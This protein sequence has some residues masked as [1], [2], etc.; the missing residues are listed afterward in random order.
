M[1]D[2]TSNETLRQM[3]AGFNS[4]QSAL[5]LLPA[6]SGSPT[7]GIGQA[8]VS[9]PPMPV[10]PHPSE[11]AMAALQRHNEM[12]QQTLQAAQATRYQPPPSSPTPS[13]GGLSLFN[14]FVANALGG[15]GGGYGLPSPSM[16]T[17]PAYGMFRPSPASGML[18]YGGA[19]RAPSIYNPLAPTLPSAHFATPAM[20]SLQVMQSQESQTMGTMAGA[21]EFGLGVA[22]SVVGGTLGS[23]FGPLGTIAGSWL[24]SKVGHLAGGMM[25]G[26]AVQDA[27]RAR[28]IQNTTAPFMVT[29][30]SLGAT[31]QGMSTSAALQTA[32][33]MRH[34]VHDLDFERTGFNTQDAMRIMGGAAQHGLLTG[35]QSPEEMVRRVKEI[36]KSV[37]L[38]MQITG[39]PDVRSALA[40]LGQMRDLGFQG[41]GAQAG[42]VANRA[43]FARMAGVSQAAAHEMFGL[44]GAMM[45]QQVGLAGATGYSAGMAGGAFANIAASSGALNDLQLS[46]AGGKSGLAQ[47]NAM[48]QLSSMQSDV[49][50]AASLKRGSK[51]LEVDMDAYRRAQGMTVGEVAREAAE[52]IHSMGSEGIFEWRTRRQE[53]KDQVAQKLTPLEMGL[54]VVK[55]AR[56][57]QREVPGM[58]LGSAIFA[59]VQSNAVG[60]GMSEEQ[61]EQAARSLELQ[62]TDRKFWEGQKQQLRAQRRGAIDQQR[63]RFGQ[64]ATQGLGESISRASRMVGL[65]MSDALSDP[66]QRAANHFRRVRED[67]EAAGYGEHITRLSAF[68]IVGDEAERK[69]MHAAQGR[70]FQA[71]YAG[72]LGADPLGRDQ[73][74]LGGAFSRQMNRMA[75]LVGLSSTSNANRLAAL[76]SESE[77]LGA[78]PFGLHPFKSFGNVTEAFERV[79]DVAAAGAAVQASDNFD[80]SRR[81]ALIARMGTGSRGVSAGAV[82]QSATSALV[83]RIDN[84]TASAVGSETGSALSHSDLKNAFIQGAKDR[85]MN[86]QE[87]AKMFD[88]N[89]GIAADMVKAVMSSGTAKQKEVL[90]K[91]ADIQVK[92]GGIDMTRSREGLRDA[93]RNRLS[94]AGLN[95]Q[96][97]SFNASG[98]RGDGYEASEKTL[99]ELSSVTAHH[100]KEEVAVAAALAAQTSGDPTQRKKGDQALSALR[101]QLGDRK[102]DELT[103]TAQDTILKGASGDLKTAL[104]R[105][106]SEGQAGG[107]TKRVGAVFEAASMSKLGAAS[108][109]LMRRLGSISSN[110]DISSMANPL[111]AIKSLTSSDLDRL[112]KD[113]P[114]MAKLLRA[115]AGGDKKAFEALLDRTAPTQREVRSGSAVSVID[116][117]MAKVNEAMADATSDG[118]MGLQ[119]ESSKLFADS[120]KTFADA[121]KDLKGTSEASNLVTG[122]PFFQAFVQP[123]VTGGG[124]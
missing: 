117:Q 29:G 110:K 83:N 94:A 68:S 15:G 72:G 74:A 109:A 40:S 14:P 58:N 11:A 64:F 101:A 1:A 114:E 106:A 42:A 91:S 115:A 79:Q 86:A 113:D 93:I 55:Q 51:G 17:P 78:T 54:N 35:T 82:L 70:G 36:S 33:G 97:A 39:D 43:M 44:P 41:T 73:G 98:F 105:V 65:Q 99:A 10:V 75:S 34:M 116:Q 81:K 23:A 9:A 100:S 3:L 24:G 12:T 122:S 92:L 80:L 90:G 31:G 121:V 96:Y 60:A 124:R 16:M 107:I 25:T 53:F 123:R 89:P 59:S 48:A 111:D 63:S 6:Q 120:V 18:P 22:G 38:L 67:E 7:I 45:A 26:P 27:A 87:A 61:A 112:E 8:T 21:A 50:L 5:G 104:V 13:S 32:R 69:M 20:R 84:L 28:M 85:G 62:Y 4:M 119:A 57:L 37:K 66:F 19:I 95:E 71:A 52:R 49:Y 30:A 46:R 2:G 77:G 103:S 76:A 102:M 108:D 88:A 47:I 118:G 56:G